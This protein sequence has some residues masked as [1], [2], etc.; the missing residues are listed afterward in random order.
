MNAQGSI[1]EFLIL[2][3]S[4]KRLQTGPPSHP[5]SHPSKQHQSALPAGLAQMPSE[6][7]EL[8]RG[9]LQRVV[10]LHAPREDRGREE[11]RI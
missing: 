7:Q 11:R 6:T 1:Q 5:S 3:A 2:H 4:L 10:S 8:R 9:G